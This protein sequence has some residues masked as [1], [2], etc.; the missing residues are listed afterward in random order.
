MMKLSLSRFPFLFLSAAALLACSS[1]QAQD[2]TLGIL[3]E[4]DGRAGG[5]SPL[6]GLTQGAD[7]TFYGVATFDG[8]NGRGLLFR[9]TPAGSYTILHQFT[10]GADG[11]FPFV[12][13]V[14]AGDGNFYGSTNGPTGY[15]AGGSVFRMTPTG[16]FTPLYSFTGGADGGGVSG[17]MQGSDGNFYGTTEG[18]GVAAGSNGFGTVFRVTSTGVLTTLYT[19]TGGADGGWPVPVAALVQGSDGNFYG[20]TQEVNGNTHLGTVFRITPKGV[21]TTLHTFS[22]L[23]DGTHAYGSLLQAS[24]GN[25]YGTTKGGGLGDAGTV[26]RL[27]ADGTFSTLHKFTGNQGNGLNEGS[28]PDGALIQG[29]DGNFYGTTENG[30]ATSRWGTAFRMTP[31]GDITTI[32]SFTYGVDGATPSAGLIQGSDGNFYGTTSDGGTAYHGTVFS[33]SFAASAHA[34]P[35]IISPP[36]SGAT[37]GQLFTYQIATLNSPTSF[38]AGALPA[39]LRFDATFGVITGF[40]TTAATQSIPISA[41]N[42]SGTDSATLKLTVDP[43]QGPAILNGSSVVA[44]TGQPLRFQLFIDGLSPA[45]TLTA[46]GLPPGL[47]LNPDN[48]LITGTVQADGSY[49]ATITITDGAAKALMFLQFTFTSDRNTPLIKPAGFSAGYGSGTV[50]LTPGQ[51]VSFT[52]GVPPGFGGGTSYSMSGN[53]PNGLS[54]DPVT[55]TIS[56]TYNPPHAEMLNATE[57]NGLN[58]SSGSVIGTVQLFTH[59]SHGTGT[60][61]VTFVKTPEHLLNIATRMRV[62][63]GNNVLIGGFIIT[64]SDPKKVLIRG[65]GPSLNGVGVTLSDPTLELHQPDGTVIT[66]DNWKFNDQTGQSQEADIR[67]TTIPPTNDLESALI[68]TLSPGAYTAILAGKSGGTGVGVVE[69]YDLAQAANSKLANISSRGFV[70]TGDNVMIGGFIVGG[71]AGGGDAKVIVRAIGPSLPVAGALGDPTLE[72]HNG[73]GTMIVTNDNWKINDQTGQS[74]E[75]DIRAT[76]IPPTSDLESAIVATLP[77]DNYTAIVRGKNNATG[78]GVVEVYNL[79]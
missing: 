59:N 67:A 1:A 79:Q 56:G 41:T 18:G 6:G 75:A 44:L 39:G 63:S 70:D 54:F 55:G 7:G 23:T 34:A 52:T 73:N 25:F 10:G 20:T 48:G 51:T 43:A 57:A 19:F 3:H 68:A 61:P 66:N 42:S 13:P 45:A 17:L 31:A 69:V 11:G 76:T 14:L 72:L 74:Q 71:G 37:V 12:A 29:K 50:G 46:S 77:P 16:D 40:P 33:L 2:A 64:G 4:F 24:D 60:A 62:L 38:T 49:V 27:A 30:G 47:T 78:I 21:L 36:T 9:V 8:E 5:G 65:I 15:D 26:F 32:Y 53:L 58:A 28:V 22:G 35:I